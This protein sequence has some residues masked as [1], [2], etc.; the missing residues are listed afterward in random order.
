MIGPPIAAE[1]HA[2]PRCGVPLVTGHRGEIK[3]T[4]AQRSDS[5]QKHRACPAVALAER[6]DVVVVGVEPGQSVRQPGG[7]QTGAVGRK[8]PR[9]FLEQRHQS[10]Q[11]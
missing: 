7:L 9:G 3:P 5:V 6:V 2:V 10:W 4:P 8:R 1:R 11:A